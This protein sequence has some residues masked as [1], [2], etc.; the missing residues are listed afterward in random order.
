[1]RAR[2]GGG[3]ETVNALNW[4]AACR[5][6]R[7]GGRLVGTECRVGGRVLACE[8]AIFSI[9]DGRPSGAKA[10]T[11]KAVTEDECTK[12]VTEDECTGDASTNPVWRQ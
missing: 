9:H 7:S 5:E 3:V 8:T 10:V 1:V 6:S 12:A 2:G 4:P 11:S